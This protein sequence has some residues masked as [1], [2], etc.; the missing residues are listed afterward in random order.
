M[1]IT[2]S[3]P[4]TRLTGENREKA[5]RRA[6]DL[7]AQGATIQAVARDLGRSYGL[8]RELLIEARVP[9]RARGG[10]RRKAAV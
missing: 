4:G 9:L 7:Y 2:S 8:A 10:G 3:S 1:T 5:T 6:V